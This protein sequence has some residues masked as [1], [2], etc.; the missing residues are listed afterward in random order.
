MFLQE[1]CEA[2]LAIAMP[3]MNAAIAALD[4]LKQND[5]SLVKT[6]TNPPNGVKLVM[7]AVCIMKALKPDKKVDGTGKAVEDFW[8]TAKKVLT[9]VDVLVLTPFQTNGIFNKAT[10]NKVRMVR[11][12]Y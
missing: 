10:Y 4:T 7:E 5:I 2:K 9:L 11:C 3:A 6:M 12:I 1:E 8:P